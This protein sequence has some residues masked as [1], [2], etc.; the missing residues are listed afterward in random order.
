ML[1]A[2]FLAVAT[3]SASPTIE[4]SVALVFIQAEDGGMIMQCSATAYDKK[5]GETLYLTAAHCVTKV[6]EKGD[7][8]VMGDDAPL[9]LSADELNVKKY[10]RA[11]LVEV[12]KRA[13]G[14]DYAI[15]SAKLDLPTVPLGDERLEPPHTDV[16]TVG[17]PTGIGK[18]YD[19]GVLSMRY[20][21]RPMY[22]EDAKINWAGT[23]LVRIQTEGGSSGSAIV[24]ATTNTIIG[25]LVGHKASLTVA[26][27]ISRVRERKPEYILYPVQKK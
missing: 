11:K 15:L 21:D 25:V 3:A 2:L 17:A 27:P 6:N 26:V 22:L 23:M 20:I 7:D 12:G 18:A 14:Y 8:E 16:Y 24:S 19:K 10:V 1:G 4:D 9:F 13:K 5:D